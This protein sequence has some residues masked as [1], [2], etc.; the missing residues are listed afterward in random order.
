MSL[1]ELEFKTDYAPEIIAL[2]YSQFNDPENKENWQKLIRALTKSRNEIEA[3]MK[4]LYT[5]RSLETA[6]GEQLDRLGQIIGLPRNGR[7]DAD[8]REALRLQIRINRGSGEPELLIEALLFFTGSDTVWLQEVYPAALI[9]YIDGTD[10]IN[11]ILTQM[12]RIRLAG[13]NFMDIAAS[14]G[15]LPPL[16]FSWIGDTETIERGG[17]YAWNGTSG[18]ITDGAGR[19]SWGI[20]E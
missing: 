8:Y 2:L 20:F 18:F 14:Y 4:D 11:N 10:I 9:A 17:T 5:Q 7:N 15:E 3:V 1:K 6:I 16:G 13:V 12:N 19:Y